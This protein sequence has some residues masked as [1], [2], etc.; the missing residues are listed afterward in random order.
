MKRKSNLKVK[1][2]YNIPFWKVQRNT[3]TQKR[4]GKKKTKQSNRKC[5]F[6]W[7]SKGKN[8][9]LFDFGT[10]PITKAIIH[11]TLIKPAI[12][13]QCEKNVFQYWQLM[14]RN[15]FLLLMF[16]FVSLKLS[17]MLFATCPCFKSSTGLQ[18]SD[19]LYF[20]A[21]EYKLLC[22]KPFFQE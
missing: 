13:A 17:E 11:I 7:Y 15:S 5:Q 18:C 14:T 19:Q 6:P 8:L 22:N 20:W 21:R 1:K 3:L 16:L 2:P 10:S 4:K 9:Q 12:I